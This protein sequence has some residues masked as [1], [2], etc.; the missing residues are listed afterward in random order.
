MAKCRD[1]DAVLSVELNLIETKHRMISKHN[2]GD[3]I[4]LHQSYSKAN[5]AFHPSGVGK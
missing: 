2:R 1:I 3:Y 5:S 4:T